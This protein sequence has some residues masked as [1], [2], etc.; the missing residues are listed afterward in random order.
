MEAR[1]PQAQKVFDRFHEQKLASEAVD[2]VRRQEVGLLGGAPEGRA[3]KKSRC[4][5]TARQLRQRCRRE[6]LEQLGQ[7]ALGERDAGAG[8]PVNDGGTRPAARDP[9]P[10]S[11]RP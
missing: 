7:Q 9:R 10:V 4:C 8:G 3:L 5:P 1:A 2:T 6:A 11:L